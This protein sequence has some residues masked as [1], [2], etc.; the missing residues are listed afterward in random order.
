[1]KIKRQRPPIKTHGGKY[2]LSPWLIDL[3]PSGFEDMTY[4]EAFAGGASLLLNKPRSKYE[5]MNDLDSD[6]ITLWTVLQCRHEEFISIISDWSYTEESFGKALGMVV[7]RVFTTDPQE[8]MN[9][10]V[11]EYVLR[12]MSRGGMKKSFAWSKRL[13][14]GKPGDVNAW[15]TMLAQLP[16]IHD[17]IKDVEIWN[18]NAVDIIPGPSTAM[19]AFVYLDPPY[20]KGTRY[21]GAIHVYDHEMSDKDHEKLLE[22]CLESG[23]KIMIS[24]Y[25]CPLYTSKL[26]GWKFK[27]RTI[28]NHSSQS[29]RKSVKLECVWMNY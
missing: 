19:N 15:E 27:F 5:L 25:Q 6:L 17:R 8:Q 28:A 24:G 26:K 4:I 3:F 14:G 2:Y 23:A 1:M 11:K 21:K 7:P 12:R 10:A 18:G 9:K 20:V 29:D 22:R 16:R 13:R